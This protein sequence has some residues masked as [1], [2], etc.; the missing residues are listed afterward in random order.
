MITRSVLI[1]IATS[2]VGCAEAMMC[3]TEV[4]QEVSSPSGRLTAVEY[5]RDCG[6]TTPLNTQLAVVTSDDKKNPAS[7][8]VFAVAGRHDLRPQWRDDDV[9]SIRLPRGQVFQ[10]E[11]KWHHVRLEYIE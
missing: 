2:L 7:G 9:L 11:S 3:A 6:A 4:T 1:A 8:R 5:H 10:Q